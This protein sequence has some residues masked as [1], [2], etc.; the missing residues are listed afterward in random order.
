MD[1]SHGGTAAADA[2]AAVDDS[3]GGTATTAAMV[4][5]ARQTQKMLRKKRK[6]TWAERW[7]GDG[8]A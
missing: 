5:R 7:I 8:I 1:G 4:A 2:T 3:P 6:Q